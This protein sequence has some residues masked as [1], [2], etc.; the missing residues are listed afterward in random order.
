MATPGTRIG[1]NGKISSGS[2]FREI[3]MSGLVWSGGPQ[4]SYVD[5]EFLVNLFG[6][7]AIQVYK[8]MAW[9]D[10]TVGAMLYTIEQLVRQVTWDTEPNMMADDPEG[11]AEFIQS[12]MDDMAHTWTDHM[13]EVLTML[14]FGW[15][16]FE[17]VYKK[18]QGYQAENTRTPTSKYT[19]GK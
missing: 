8:E 10:P 3:G 5:E 18:R 7:R 14:P 11:D 9:N 12:C 19:D 13:G 4:W 16:W 6:R 1:P 17:I 15:S 2:P